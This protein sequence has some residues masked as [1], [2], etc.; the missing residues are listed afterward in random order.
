M[1]W[2]G[3]SLGWEVVEVFT[4]LLIKA[5]L[6]EHGPHA[7]SCFGWIEEEEGVSAAKVC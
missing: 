1:F 7:R 4:A 5:R 6:G 3:L 2:L